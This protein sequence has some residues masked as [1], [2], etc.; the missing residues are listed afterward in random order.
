MNEFE[1]GKKE[2]GQLLVDYRIAQGLTRRQLSKI[3][4]VMHD[5][6]TRERANKFLRWERGENLPT[7]YFF[8]KLKMVLIRGPEKEKIILKY[9]KLRELK[10]TNGGKRK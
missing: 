2:F 4:A 7:P 5:L 3:F 9:E 1:K 6:D 10:K 8:A